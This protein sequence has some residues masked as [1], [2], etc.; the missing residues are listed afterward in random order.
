MKNKV[1]IVTGPIGSGKSTVLSIFK[2]LGFNVVD[3]DVISGTILITDESREFIKEYFPTCIVNNKVS[4]KRIAEIVFNNK[5]ELEKLENYLHPIIMNKLNEII[6][7]NDGITFVEASA[8]KN[9]HKEFETLVIWAPEN[10]RI[11]RL[12]IRGMEIEDINN[13]INTQ[14]NDE[15]WLSIGTVIK[16]DNLDQLHNELKDYLDINL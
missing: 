9:I 13:R 16:N 8:P 10:V 12:R 7:Q 14:A 15:W 3:L 1:I 11:E 2:N 4:K 5:F 6:N